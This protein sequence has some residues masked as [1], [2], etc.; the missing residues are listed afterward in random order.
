MSDEEKWTWDR[1]SEIPQEK[2]HSAADHLTDEDAQ[3]F[4]D[5]IKATDT[6]K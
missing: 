2:V 3:F 5:N 6:P 1:Q 4:K